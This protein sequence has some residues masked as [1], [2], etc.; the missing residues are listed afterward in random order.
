MKYINRVNLIT[1]ILVSL[2]SNQ[3][4][5]LATLFG[6]VQNGNTLNDQ[7][8]SACHQNMFGGDGSKIFTRQ[9]HQIKTVEGL[10]KRVQVCNDNTQNGELNQSQLD[11]IT[12]YLNETFYK[13][14]D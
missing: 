5:A 13:F 14:E 10:M 3:A 9:D 4:N 8:C 11:D 12:I 2:F 7:R 6:D 1:G